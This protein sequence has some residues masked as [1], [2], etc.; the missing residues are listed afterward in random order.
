METMT[1]AEQAMQLLFKKLH[2]HLEDAAHAL[3]TGARAPDLE[4]LNGKLQRACHEASEVLDGLAA[5]CEGELGELLGTL[6][7]NLLPVGATYQQQLILVQLCLEEAP[8]EL[9][10]FT[11]PGSAAA[12][13]WGKR[14]R[15]FLARLEDPAFQSR[16]RWAGIDP[17]IGDE[18][19]EEDEDAAPRGREAGRRKLPG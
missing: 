2:P 11:P 19:L 6:S 9:L 7:A 8:A 17:D 10:A 18:A 5:A 3:A 14:M 16:A 13:G 15:D 12:S 4:K 1:P